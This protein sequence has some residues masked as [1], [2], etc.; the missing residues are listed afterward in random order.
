MKESP[1]EDLVPLIGE[2]KDELIQ[3]AA[4]L[5]RKEGRAS[6]SWLQRKL[7]IGFPRAARLMDELE[8][9]GVVGPMD[10][11]ERDREIL[12]DDKTSEDIEE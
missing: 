1:W 3:K 6:T 5:I 4:E 7:H 2:D 11:G 8:E 9:L 12:I 10:S